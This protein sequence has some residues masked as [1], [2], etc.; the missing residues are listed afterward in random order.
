MHEI[1]LLVLWMAFAA[2]GATPHDPATHRHMD[3]ANV[4]NPV[5]ATPES[6]AAGGKLYVRNCASCHG[7]TGQGDG[8]GGALLKPKP[9]NLADADWKHGT[10]DGEIFAVVHTGI[11][12][13]PMK[14]FASKMTEH[15]IWD[16]INYIRSLG[17]KS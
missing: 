14:P 15:E 12:K 13:S 5:A 3:E 4:K 2:Q 17:P 16:V 7:K 1:G 8:P 10:S 11:Q 6:I 9:A